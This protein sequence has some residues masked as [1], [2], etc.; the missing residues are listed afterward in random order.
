MEDENDKDD[1]LL[2]KVSQPHHLAM[3][4]HQPL[5][6][7]LRAPPRVIRHPR[8]LAWVPRSCQ[9]VI[10]RQEPLL[11]GVMRSAET[12]SA[13]LASVFVVA[14]VSEPRQVCPEDAGFEMDMLGLA[15]QDTA[16]APSIL[17]LAFPRKSH[18]HMERSMVVGGSDPLLQR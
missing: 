12:P 5:L 18:K 14:R 1:C 6:E 17:P 9:G 15:M 16:V 4:V 3:Q 2:H 10:S 7:L 8:A 13:G 11:S